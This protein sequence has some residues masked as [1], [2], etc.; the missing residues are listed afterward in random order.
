MKKSLSLLAIVIGMAFSASAF[1]TKPGNNGGGNGGCGVG[2]TTN[3]CGTTTT[4]NQGD[5][6]NAP[7]ANGGQGGTGIGV[8]GAVSGS[9]ASAESSAAAGAISGSLATGGSAKASGGAA[10]AQAGT[11][12]IS[13]AGDSGDTFV[14]PAPVVTYVPQSNGGIVTKSHAVGLGWNLISWSKSEQTLDPVIG[15]QKLVADLERN[16]QFLSASIVRQRISALL[17][18]SYAELPA[19]PGV[20]NLPPSECLRK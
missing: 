8:S 16:C 13:V 19:Q 7:V 3:G 15:A 9:K 14:A 4:P 18:P 12:D 20:V 17:F 2:Q 10:G 6:T 5:T 1:A 11:G